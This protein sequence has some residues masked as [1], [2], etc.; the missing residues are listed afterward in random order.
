[1]NNTNS[2]EKLKPLEE[3]KPLEVELTPIILRELEPLLVNGE[4]A[5]HLLPI[6]ARKEHFLIFTELR[7]IYLIT[8]EFLGQGRFYSYPYETVKSLIIKER[9]S[10]PS[11]SKG[12]LWFLIDY[13]SNQIIFAE[14]F[15]SD[16]MDDVKE[17]MNKIP[18]FSDIPMVNKVYGRS[19]FHRIINNP[20]SA[21][22]DRMKRNI[23]VVLIAILLVAA[24]VAR[25][26]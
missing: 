10:P 17:L 12:E 19:K 6:P 15:H 14:L 11:D 8:T 20:E 22:D 1:M 16:A 13:T 23:A 9:T 24:L 26:L 25:S 7:I 3:S 18:A 2:F 4:N 21:L 5:H